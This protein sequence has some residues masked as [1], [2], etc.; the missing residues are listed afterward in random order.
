MKCILFAILRFLGFYVLGIV[1]SILITP[2]EVDLLGRPD[3]LIFVPAAVV[4][5]VLFYTDLTPEYVFGSGPAYWTV[6]ALGL[7]GVGIGVVAVFAGRGR[8]RR[9]AA[10]LIALPLGF[11]GTLG[12]WYS[13]LASI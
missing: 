7:A 8:F 12:I 3:W 9:W 5:Y 10:P 1:A 2:V 11:V 13:I 4:G 6:Y